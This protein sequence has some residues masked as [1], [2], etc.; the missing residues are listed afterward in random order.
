MSYQVTFTE[1]TNP[2][3][4][5]LTVADQTLNTQ[6]SLTFVGKNY[7]GY[8]PVVANNFLH[9]LENFANNSA[10]AN[11]IEGQLWYDNTSGVSLLKVFDGTIWTSAGSVKKAS[12]A[13]LAANSNPGDLW[14]NTTTAQLY[15]FSG[16]NWLLVGP[17]FS[18]G[19]LTG[20]VVDTIIDTSNVTHSVIS[21]YANN[22]Q[23]AIIS[24]ETFTPKSTIV[25]FTTVNQGF[26]LSNIDS[27]NTTGLSRIWGTA[28]NADALLVTGVSVP[29]ANFLRSDTSS[30]SNFPLTIRADGGLTIGSN[31]SFNI[32]RDGTSTILYSKS[33]GDS[34]DF[35][36]NNNSTPVTVLHL[37]AL[38][39][40]GIGSNNTAPTAT[41]DVA[42]TVTVSGDLSVT[43]T[44]DATS[45]VTG[46]IKTAGGISVS[47]NIKIGNN[48]TINGK[49]YLNTLD[50]LTGLETPG[51][52]ILPSSTGIFDIGSSIA[53]FRNVYADSFVGDFSGTFT[54]TLQ[55]SISGSAARLASPTTFSMTGDVSSDNIS[56]TGQSSF[57]TATFTT[58][59]SQ[60]FI[61][62]KPAVDNSLLSD[63]LLVYRSGSANLV[64]MTKETLLSHVATVPIGVIMP[65][66]GTIIPEGY[67][68]CDGS[69]VKTADYPGLYGVIGYTY[70][71][72]TLL[73]GAAT[74][75]LPDLRGRFPLGRDNMD[76]D[77]RIPSR[78]DA[79]ILI[80]A[81][82]GPANRVTDVTADIVG[83]GSGAQT[84]TL[85][86]NNLPDHK[87]NLSS[88][89][90]QYYAA[91]LPSGISDTSAVPGLGLPNS[92]TGSGL[93]NSGGII[94][95][96]LG[97]A[98]TIMN[99]YTTINYIIFTG[100]L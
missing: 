95:S 93:P 38:S 61:S 64:K 42:G 73:S 58:T 18:S 43:S 99:P 78:D 87:H 52:V 27:T 48:A 50:P 2:A 49:L 67:L 80:D 83:T 60:N 11:P 100:V 34:V 75:S 70:K 15:V 68:L 56:F 88:T 32:G 46:S 16:S 22:Y 98:L 10:P 66:A 12:A 29:S 96:T 23:L 9:L 71:S 74:F 69:E 63:Q 44:T 14:V 25:G 8:A 4:P 55:G 97:S 57:G 24:K 26:N 19:S 7:A 39:R 1:T 86:I 92:S 31:S 84:V 79:S 36:L 35:K 53:K 94:S 82:G 45:L 65:F 3:K 62:N 72:A 6:T 21:L 30:T 85:S 59:I 89:S 76:N 40:V 17:Q 28:S 41:L 5:A 51:S 81:G 47:K 54:G 20:T 13:P 91:G 77:Q 90:A 37:N 33:S